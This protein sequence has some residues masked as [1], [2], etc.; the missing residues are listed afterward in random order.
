MDGTG[1]TVLSVHPGFV[2][3]PM[4]ERLAYGDGGRRWFPRFGIRAGRDEWG[5]EHAAAE[6][7]EAVALGAADRLA[8]RVLRIGDDLADLA[9]RC[10]AD[11]D[12][13]RLRLALDWPG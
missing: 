10:D 5:D 7:V 2:R 3:T 8:G 6:L 1:V 12:L 11:P 9:E 13:R 4:T